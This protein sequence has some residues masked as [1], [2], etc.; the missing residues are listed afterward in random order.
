MPAATLQTGV[1]PLQRLALVAEHWPH[2]P[3]GWHAGSAPPHS[4][5]A[6]QPRQVRL[7]VSQTPVGAAQSVLARQP[8][9]RPAAV[10]HSGVAPVHAAAF[11]AEHWPHAPPG[12]HAGVA[13]LHSPS[14]AQARHTCV[15]RL[16][17]GVAPPQPV[18]ATQPTQTPGPSVAR[19]GRAGA[20]AA[21]ARRALAARAARLTGRRRA[22]AVAVARARAAGVAWCCRRLA[23]RRRTGLTITHA[24]HVPVGAWHSGV[25]PVHAVALPAEHWPHAPPGWHAGVAPPHS[26]SPAQPRH[27][28]NAG[29]QTGVAPLQSVFARHDTHTPDGA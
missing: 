1:A 5:S 4:V 8:T 23:C 16:Q 3:P 26:L 22:A 24:T 27:E 13:P 21:L 11:D 17:T 10:S 14:P 2:A 19:G 25:V 6:A 12:W 18:L 7:A 20:Q 9:Q 29:S 28:W 15:V